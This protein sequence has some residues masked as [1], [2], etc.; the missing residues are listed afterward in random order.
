[1]AAYS[2]PSFPYDIIVNIIQ[3][4][5]DVET[6]NSWLVATRGSALLHRTAIRKKWTQIRLFQ[7]GLTTESGSQPTNGTHTQPEGRVKDATQKLCYWPSV[8]YPTPASYVRSAKLDIHYLVA[9]DIDL[10]DLPNCEHDSLMLLL[11]SLTHLSEL[12]VDGVLLQD[13]LDCLARLKT[14]RALKL[15]KSCAI[16]F[17][18]DVA[19]LAA[20]SFLCMKW[21]GLSQLEILR[22]LEVYQLLPDEGASFAEA[23][24]SLTHLERLLVS[25]AESPSDMYEYME[26]PLWNF[27]QAVFPDTPTLDNPS[28]TCLLPRSLKSLVLVDMGWGLTSWSGID[29]LSKGSNPAGFTK[30]QDVY[31]C[32]DWPATI[33]TLL[34]WLRDSPISRL[35]IPIPATALSPTIHV[36]Q[37][38]TSF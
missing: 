6:L 5:D 19:Y 37:I 22:K 29:N 21:D 13:I 38:L 12:F 34:T 28:Q 15:R 24:K 32:L 27:L 7:H 1:M 20:T 4:T 18:K 11:P 33:E 10:Y 26:P 8:A 23:L 36:D 2:L 14:L 3:W 9:Y 25:A 35:M 30:L 16:G 31:F 17:D